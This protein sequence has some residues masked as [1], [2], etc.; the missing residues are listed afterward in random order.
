M[1]ISRFSKRMFATSKKTTKSRITSQLANV[2][3]HGGNNSFMIAT[4]SSVQF[5]NVSFPAAKKEKRY[6]K[7]V[8]LV[9]FIT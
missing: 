6:N 8:T 2:L 4:G 7:V 9:S 1:A 5:S 3:G